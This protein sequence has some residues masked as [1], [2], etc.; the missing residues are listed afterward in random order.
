MSKVNVR[1]SNIVGVIK[2]W[3]GALGLTKVL[4]NPIFALLRN[5]IF[6]GTVLM[7]WTELTFRYCL[8][9]L[10]FFSLWCGLSFLMAPLLA[11][12]LGFVVVHTMMWTLN[13]H[14]WA[15]K[16]SEN[17]RLVR[18]SPYRIIQYIE[19]LEQR[20]A[21]TK[22][23]TACVLSGSLT[24][25]KFH[26]YSDLDVWFTKKGGFFNGLWAYLLGVRERS[27]AFIQ[28]IPI[29]L[30]FYD[31]DDYTG[32]DSAETLLLVKDCGER[33]KMVEPEGVSLKDHTWYEA[34][35]F[36]DKQDEGSV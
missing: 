24:C 31:P 13:G 34:E 5:W 6:Q 27:I 1:Q 11:A 26:A 17:R 29:E 14:F 20:L 10:L 9:L 12:V 4:Q 21:G 22:L 15:I 25:E 28:R 3:L 18:N 8:E 7:H 16:I 32:K 2:T 23:I 35:F 19:G 30:Y 36:A 33:W